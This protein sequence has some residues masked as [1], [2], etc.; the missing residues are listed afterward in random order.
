VLIKSKYPLQREESPLHAEQISENKEENI[1]Q[2]FILL[3]NLN[4]FTY[5]YVLQANQR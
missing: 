3:P 1:L 5:T 4:V 2:M